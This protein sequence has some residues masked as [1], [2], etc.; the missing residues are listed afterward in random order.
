M[1]HG[2]ST[3]LLAKGEVWFLKLD[4]G[5]TPLTNLLKTVN[6]KLKIKRQKVYSKIKV[7]LSFE[8]A[9]V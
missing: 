7:N 2:E 5:H 8:N 3:L 6:Y 1:D 9:V 4:C